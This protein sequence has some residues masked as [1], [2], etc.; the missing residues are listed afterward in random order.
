MAEQINGYAVGFIAKA[1]KNVEAIMVHYSSGQVFDG[2]N[3]EGY[4]EDDQTKPVNA[5]GR[6][7]LMGE[8]ELTENLENFYLI[9][10]CWLYGTLAAGKKSFTDIMIDLAAKGETVYAVN[11]EFGSP[12]YVVDLAQATRAVVEEKKPFGTYHLTNSGVASRYD[13]AEEIFST[14]KIE[15]TLKAVSSSFFD[16][17]APRPKYEILNNSNFIALRPWSEALKEY[18]T[19]IS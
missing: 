10:T 3:P 15:T 8:M 1:A 11:E 7:K 19:T 14:K 18:L 9:R 13:W 4:N 16:R 12:T 2:K 5:Y 17:P 6:S